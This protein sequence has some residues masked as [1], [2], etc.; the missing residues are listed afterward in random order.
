MGIVLTGMGFD[1][2]EGLAQI[3]AVGGLT[4]AQDRE[5]SIIF[6]MPKAAIERGVVDGVLSLSKIPRAIIT[7]MQTT[8]P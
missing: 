7:A 4:L 1:G 2:A 3:K 6:G 8:K 5:S